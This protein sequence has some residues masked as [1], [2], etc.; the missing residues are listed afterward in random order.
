MHFFIETPRLILR[1]FI[2]DDLA[3]YT[4]LSQNEKYQRFY[5][6]V[7]CS[8]SKATQLVGLFI[9][10]AAETPR[11]KFQLAMIDK[12]SQQLIGTAGLRV[13]ADQQA[14]IGCGIARAYQGAG[15]AAEAMCALVAYGF[16]QQN[17]HRI[18]AETIAN[19]KAAIAL[20]TQFGMREEARFLEHRY[21][22]N[23]W[24]DT[25]ILAILKSE[26]QANY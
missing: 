3:A 17:L 15:H 4:A 8:S 7:D 18:Y 12:T 25:V 26:W 11:N 20:C 14:S 9:E 6:K 19:N 23:K 1:D 2:A 21:F 5:S 16:K 22:K 10:Q 13:E 24:W